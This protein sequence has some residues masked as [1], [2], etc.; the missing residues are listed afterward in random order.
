[1]F[2]WKEKNKFLLVLMVL[3]TIF[4][5]TLSFSVDCIQPKAIVVN[6][7]LSVAHRIKLLLYKPHHFLSECN[8][9]FKTVPI[10]AGTMLQM[11]V[12]SVIDLFHYHIC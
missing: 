10:Q 3:D 9:A 11:V 12:D 5:A 2:V 8:A 6:Q 7:L 4:L 1:M